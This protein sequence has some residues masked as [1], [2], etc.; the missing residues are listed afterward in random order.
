MKMT[1]LKAGDKA[2]IISIKA[3][4]EVATRLIDM[5]LVKGTRF[6]LIRKAPLGDPI[7]IM[8]RGFFLSLRLNEAE[9]IS[10]EKIG[11]VGD[12]KPMGGGRRGR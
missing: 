2:E 6:K 4:G 12:G 9:N 11:H 8:L 10:V 7:E 1:E 3:R 5:G